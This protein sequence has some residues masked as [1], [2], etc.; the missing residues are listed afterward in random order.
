[1]CSSDLSIDAST[2][3]EWCITNCGGSP[4]NCPAELCKCEAPA[5]G[6]PAEA[7]AEPEPEPEPVDEAPTWD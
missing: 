3:T 5:G 4:P 6:A 1:M 2:P 7:E